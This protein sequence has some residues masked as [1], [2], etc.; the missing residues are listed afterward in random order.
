M[1]EVEDVVMGFCWSFRWRV[2]VL[3]R[4]PA[5]EQ[6]ALGVGEDKVARWG[7]VSLVDDGG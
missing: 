5:E 1:S 6:L 4:R 3:G 7:W 2:V